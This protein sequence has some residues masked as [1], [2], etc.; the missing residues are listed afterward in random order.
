MKKIVFKSLK[1]FGIST[2]I[3]LLAMFLYPILFPGKIEK[4]IKSFAND[5][6][7]DELNFK[8]ANLSFFNHFPSLTLSL[9]EFILK[10]SE[11]FKK[12]TLVSVNEIAF[13]INL[14]DLILE[15]KVTIDEIYLSDAFM[16]VKV[17]TKEKQTIMSM[18]LKV[19]MFPKTQ[20]QQQLDW[21]K[22][23]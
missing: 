13:E 9:E 18:F 6:L 1:I 3:L 15:G 17:N 5:N 2:A 20:C 22:F 4:E 8:E 16:N 21:I 7:N 12:G 10:G 11:P 14:K 19:K 23:L